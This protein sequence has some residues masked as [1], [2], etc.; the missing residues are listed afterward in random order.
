MTQ[1]NSKNTLGN[2]F[3]TKF[4]IER[5]HYFPLYTCDGEVT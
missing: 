3:G 1:D 4:I 5:K 2:W